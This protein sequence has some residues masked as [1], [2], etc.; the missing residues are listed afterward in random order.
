MSLKGSF[1]GIGENEISF[2]AYAFHPKADM[3]TWIIITDFLNE[4][5]HEENDDEDPVFFH[6]TRKDLVKAANHVTQIFFPKMRLNM[7]RMFYLDHRSKRISAIKTSFS[8]PILEFFGD[9]QY[10]S[11]SLG[12]SS[13]DETAQL[14]ADS[15]ETL[16]QL[17]Y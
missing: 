14:M 15:I 2:S 13:H 12:N 16:N 6:P 8:T 10:T 4:T 3:A 11:A 17:P 7:F 1:E 9:W 5:L